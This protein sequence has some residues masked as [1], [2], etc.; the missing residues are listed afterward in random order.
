MNK[1]IKVGL[2]E[3]EENT[4]FELKAEYLQ[5]ADSIEPDCMNQLFIS[6]QDAGNG[7]YFSIKTERWCFDDPKELLD[8]VTDFVHRFNGNNNLK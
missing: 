5:K 1:Q 2:P 4:I 7:H 6:T 3:T 8:L